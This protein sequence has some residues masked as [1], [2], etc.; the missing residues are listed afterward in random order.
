MTLF[1][2]V[3]LL[4]SLVFL[5]VVIVITVG[6][7]ERYGSIVKGQLQASAQDMTTTL[8]IAISNSSLGA[9]KPAYETLFNA[10]FDS[11]YYSSIEL[12]APDGELV[13]KKEQATG[14]GGSP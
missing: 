14:G 5:L 12:V 10:V 9:D 8:G 13:H 4:V 11:G 2:Q 6:S 7:L 1:K 3:A